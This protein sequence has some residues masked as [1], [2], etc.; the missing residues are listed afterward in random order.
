MTRSEEMT[1]LELEGGIPGDAGDADFIKTLGDHFKAGYQA[2]S[3]TTTEEARVES[4]IKRVAEAWETQGVITWDV[5]SGFSGPE[6]AEDPKYCVPVTALKAVVDPSG[7]FKGDHVFIFRDLDDYY[8]NPVVVR[9]IRTLTEGNKLVNGK[10]KRPIIIISPKQNIH[11]KIKACLTVVDFSLPGEAK[12]RGVVDFVITS[13][14]TSE[15]GK[16]A[17][18]DELAEQI[19]NSMRGMTAGEAEN[20][21]SRCLVIHG[22]FKPEMIATLTEEKANIIKKGDILTFIPEEKQVSRDEIGGFGELLAYIERGRLA[23]SKEAR[24]LGI[25]LPAGIILIGPPGTG[26]SMVAKAVCQL[27]GVAGFIMNWSATYG[28]LVGQ[29]EQ[30]LRDTFMTIESQQGCVVLIDEADKALGGATDGGGDNGVSKRAFGSLLTWLADKNDRT[31]V[32]MTM[33]RTDG[34]PPELLRPGRFDAVFHT[35]LPNPDE[36]KEITKIHMNRRNVDIA[37]VG[38]GDAEWEE[39]VNK[40][41]DFSGADLE[42]VIV[43][44]RAFSFQERRT[45]TPNLTEL[46]KAVAATPATARGP[47]KDDIDR[48][49]S[50]CKKHGTLPVSTPQKKKR[51]TV[52]RDR[53]VDITPTDG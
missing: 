50:F 18:S 5:A 15:K 38:L 2:L 42:Q 32:I 9:M 23:Y 22:G 36:R 20:A 52:E 13:I 24:E 10:R 16:A 35:D 44:A 41:E 1:K 8:N 28:S 11:P 19:V 6:A 45:G 33:N 7:P 53:S 37:T 48:I 27:F 3:I 12:L 34:I 43:N 14:K 29:T 51:K 40:T 21:L 17:C 47:G 26:K 49:R 46:F 30:N 39:F 4:D 31:F 25:D